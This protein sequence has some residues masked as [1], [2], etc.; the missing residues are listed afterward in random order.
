MLIFLE[1]S[2]QHFT[3]ITSFQLNVFHDIQQS[4][5]RFLEYFH[6]LILTITLQSKEVEAGIV[7]SMFLFRI[8]TF[9]LTCDSQIFSH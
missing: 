1:Y 7:R 2:V 4:W 9:Y 3:D 8:F 6:H 5:L